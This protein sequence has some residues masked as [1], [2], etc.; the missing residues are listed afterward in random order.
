MGRAEAQDEIATGREGAFKSALR[1]QP[2]TRPSGRRCR[3]V[4]SGH[5]R[6]R[7]AVSRLLDGAPRPKG[8]ARG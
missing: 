6:Q 8:E 3:A 7:P 5:L 2:K 4:S 1:A